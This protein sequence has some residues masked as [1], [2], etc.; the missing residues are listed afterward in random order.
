MK[1]LIL[2]IVTIGLAMGAYAQGLVALSDTTQ[3]VSTNTGIVSGGLYELPGAYYFEM[4]FIPNTGQAAPTY[5]SAAF[6]TAGGA[7]QGFTDS[8]LTGTNAGNGAPTAGKLG[9]IVGENGTAGIA[10]NGWTGSTS[11]FYVVLG[12]SAGEGTFANV[13]TALN[14]GSWL[15]PTGYFG[16][17]MIGYANANLT[18]VGTILFG[19]ATGLINAGWDLNPVP[20]PSVMALAGLGGLSLLLLRR[21]H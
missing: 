1:K 14:G 4:L 9:K 7:L 15:S 13:E 3:V 17:S 2:S 6:G 21:R 20:E 5:S 12:W 10:V 16:Y 8:T 18:G 11:A 19:S